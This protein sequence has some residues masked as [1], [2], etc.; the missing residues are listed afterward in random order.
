MV[1]GAV[2]VVVVAEAVSCCPISVELAGL[3]AAAGVLCVVLL[4][5]PLSASVSAVDWSS[6]RSG[7]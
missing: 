7:L 5:L 4:V 6:F 1:S 2:V 3:L